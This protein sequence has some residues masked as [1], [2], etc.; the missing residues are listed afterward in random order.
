MSDSDPAATPA[1]RLRAP[2]RAEDLGLAAWL[3]VVAPAGAAAAGPEIAEGPLA[4][5]VMVG[6]TL[7]AIVCL[8]TRPTD[9]PG[10]RTRDDGEEVAPRWILAGPLVGGTAIIS[11]TGFDQ[12]GVR[13]VDL[14]GFVLLVAIGALVANRWLPAV[15]ATVRRLLVLPFTLVAGSFF[16]GLAAS[17]LDTVEVGDV[18]SAI[19]TPGWGITAFVLLMVVGGLAAFYAMLVVAPRQ[20]ADPEDAGVRWVLRFVLFLGASLLGIG[21]LSLLG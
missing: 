12:L 4:G 3:G 16:T 20:L 8:A 11:S 1:G 9:Q 7:L 5:L 14:S 10:L 6:A 2:F 15:P 19:G 13:D 21:W 18:L 17:I